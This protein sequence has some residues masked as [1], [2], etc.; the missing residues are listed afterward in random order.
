MVRIWGGTVASAD[1][2]NCRSRKPSFCILSFLPR[3]GDQ[4]MALHF[5]QF[6]NHIQSKT[7]KRP[8]RWTSFCLLYKQLHH[9]RQELNVVFWVLL[10]L[11]LHLAGELS[12]GWDLMDLLL[13]RWPNRLLLT[14]KFGSTENSSTCTRITNTYLSNLMTEDWCQFQQRALEKCSILSL[15]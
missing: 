13:L 6:Q 3:C 5:L 8:Y 7:A 4:S 12:D 2:I 11:H 14:T 1:M 15:N 10:R 9:A